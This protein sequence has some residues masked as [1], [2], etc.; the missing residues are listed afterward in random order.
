[1]RSIWRWACGLASVAVAAGLLGMVYHFVGDVI[2]GGF[3]G[4][5]VGA[6][7]A[8]YTG[9]GDPHRS[10]SSG[11]RSGYCFKYGLGD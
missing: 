3:V 2:A 11:T 9:L 10:A 8:H 4:G 1:M 7:T 6:Y 5:I